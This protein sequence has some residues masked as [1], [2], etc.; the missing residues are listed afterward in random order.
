MLGYYVERK[1]GW[2][3]HGLPVEVEVE[4]EGETPTAEK[5][6]AP[7]TPATGS[8]TFINQVATARDIVTGTLVVLCFLIH[9]HYQTVGRKLALLFDQLKPAVMEGEPV[10]LSSPLDPQKPTAAVLVAAYSGLGIHTILNAF[11]IGTYNFGFLVDTKIF[12]KV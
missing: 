1:A 8:V 7:D 11:K 10:P 4:D 3:T 6:D 9:R 12:N 5:R 2:D